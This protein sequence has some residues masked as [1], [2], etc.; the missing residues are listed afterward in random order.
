MNTKPPQVEA[1]KKRK[2]RS[3]SAAKPGYG[4]KLVVET[5]E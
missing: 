2:K 4:L 1:R 5:R 3:S